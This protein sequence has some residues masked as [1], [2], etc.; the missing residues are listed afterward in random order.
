MFSTENETF[1]VS[2]A[3]ETKTLKLDTFHLHEKTGFP[4]G[5]PIPTEIFK[6]KNEIPSELLEWSE[7]HCFIILPFNSIPMLLVEILHFVLVGNEMEH[8]P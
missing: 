5:K 2:F 4:D 1:F 7:N 6:K 3:K 8:S